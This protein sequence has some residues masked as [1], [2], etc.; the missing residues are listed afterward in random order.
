MPRRAGA[1]PQL[2]QQYYQ[3]KQSHPQ[4]GEGV[5]PIVFVME[6]TDLN[7]SQAW[8][9]VFPVYFIVT[10]LFCLLESIDEELH[11]TPSQESP[12]SHTNGVDQDAT[13]LSMAEIASCSYEAR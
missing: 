12:D 1:N 8:I 3:R 11:T 9:G 6:H 2:E 4:S 7:F 10:S 13:A 5:T